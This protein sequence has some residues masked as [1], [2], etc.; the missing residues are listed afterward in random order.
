[1]I[2]DHSINPLDFQDVLLGTFQ[3]YS[4]FQVGAL[5]VINDQISLDEEEDEEDIY[6]NRL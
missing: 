4:S 5:P 2:V 1:M 6:I 3:A